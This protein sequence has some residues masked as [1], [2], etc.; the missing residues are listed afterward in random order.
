VVLLMDMRYGARVTVVLLM[1]M[2]YGARSDSGVV[3]NSK[4]CKGVALVASSRKKEPAGFWEACVPTGQCAYCSAY[5]VT[6]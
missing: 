1:D 2:R 6:V 5:K 4:L 3:S